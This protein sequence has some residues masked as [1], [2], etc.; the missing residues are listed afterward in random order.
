M[1]HQSTPHERFTFRTKLEHVF[2]EYAVAKAE[3]YFII[4]AKKLTTM[5]DFIKYYG[6][7]RVYTMIS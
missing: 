3:Q 4:P 5:L 6:S 2:A 1:S 7:Y